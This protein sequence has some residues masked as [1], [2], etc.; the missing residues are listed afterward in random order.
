MEDTSQ[1][2]QEPAS[3]TSTSIEQVTR[4]TASA[5]L[6]VYGLGFVIVGF[7][8]ARYGVVQFSPFRTKIL[9]VGFVFTAL[10]ALTA[11]A[12]HYQFAYLAP[13]ETVRNDSNPERRKHKDTVLAAGFFFTAIFMASLL[14]MFLFSAHTQQH[15][16][17][18]R[19]LLW[20]AS[21][22]LVWGIFVFINK[23][24]TTK[25]VRAVFLSIFTYVLF[26]VSL[27][28]TL[29]SSTWASLTAF[30]ALVGFETA[31]IKR[32]RSRLENQVVANKAFADQQPFHAH[33]SIAAIA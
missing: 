12:Q 32:H 8:D 15:P 5:L 21:Y 9:L 23:T 28:E 10:V 19:L 24:F 29:P 2:E 26:L 31:A 27:G 6:L 25:P 20:F 30:F 16:N 17:K 7:H 1:E 3:Q 14:N 13:L 33:T 4:V 18:W 11:G 22:G